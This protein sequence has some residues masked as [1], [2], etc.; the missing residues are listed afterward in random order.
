MP[1][2]W[3]AGAVA[4]A[5]VVLIFATRT[6]LFVLDRSRYTKPCLLKQMLFVA[7]TLVLGFGAVLSFHIAQANASSTL[8]FES[9]DLQFNVQCLFIAC[10]VGVCGA[11][12][13]AYIAMDDP[14]YCITEK[15]ARTKLLMAGLGEK[16]TLSAMLNKRKTEREI[17]YQARFSNLRCVTVGAILWSIT[18]TAVRLL[19]TQARVG[20]VTTS[21]WWVLCLAAGVTQCTAWVAFWSIFRFMTFWPR[22]ARLR[23]YASALLAASIAVPQYVTLACSTHEVDPVPPGL[24]VAAPTLVANVTLVALS[25]V[26]VVL[27]GLLHCGSHRLFEDN[28]VHAI[29]P[30]DSSRSKRHLSSITLH[31]SSR[32][33]R[34]NSARS[35][36]LN[37]P[38]SSRVVTL[39]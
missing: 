20:M 23:W 5:V 9:G 11:M 37:R 13:S 33:L 26:V 3:S 1:T 32:S 4:T 24:G 21:P 34:M 35:L 31:S 15:E 14:F 28:S 25:L 8:S 7:L 30:L 18:V 27:L 16:M 39:K 17:Q 29:V 12:A 36:V 22:A 6:A 10:G 2:S 38:R 19:V